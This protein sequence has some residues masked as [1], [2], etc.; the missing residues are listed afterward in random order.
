MRT[1]EAIII[2]NA[3]GRQAIKGKVFVDSSG[4]AEVVARAGAPFVRGGG[5]QTLT[6]DS[7]QDEQAYSGRKSLDNDKHRL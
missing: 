3:S 6:R 1:I 5:P 7:A 2:E 4:T